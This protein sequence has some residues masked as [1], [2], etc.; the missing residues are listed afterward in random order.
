MTL[1]LP[2]IILQRVE[3]ISVLPVGLHAFSA[4]S[5]VRCPSRWAQQEHCSGFYPGKRLCSASLAQ[6]AVAQLPHLSLGNVVW[7]HLSSPYP[8]L[9]RVPPYRFP[10]EHRLS[11][12]VLRPYSFSLYVSVRLAVA[13]MMTPLSNVPLEVWKTHRDSECSIN[14]IPISFF[15]EKFSVPLILYACPLLSYSFHCC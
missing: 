1:F 7:A 10:P 3:W 12:W 6:P 11:C 5:C 15:S 4:D 13:D 2:Q 9:T 8:L 14:M